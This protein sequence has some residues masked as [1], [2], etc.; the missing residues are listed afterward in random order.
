M[1]IIQPSRKRK[2]GSKPSSSK[3]P[4]S[5]IELGDIVCAHKQDSPEN[6][7]VMSGGGTGKGVSINTKPSIESAQ[8]SDGRK[9]RRSEFADVSFFNDR[10]TEQNV[11]AKSLKAGT[12]LSDEAKK[13]FNR[14]FLSG[15][16]LLATREHSVKEIVDK[17]LSKTEFSDIAYAVV[18]E[19][20]ENKY[21]SDQRFA[22]SYIR[23]RASKGF[24]PVKIRS[25][26]KNKGIS[27]QLIDEYMDM[28]SAAWFDAARVQHHKKYG[29]APV[30]DYNHWTKR[31][32]FMQS[33]G[34]TM[35]QIQ[36]TLPRLE[37]D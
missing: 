32:R 19:L 13:E 28:G 7:S 37:F 1:R 20:L 31:A 30:S 5:T 36:V 11:E 15:M 27:D 8:F 22:E 4:N 23:S 18:D 2:T 35:E 29:D 14:L 17:L 33:R 34:F 3:S 21:L 24:G 6:S 25:E 10:P 12:G 16:R 26:L 9:R